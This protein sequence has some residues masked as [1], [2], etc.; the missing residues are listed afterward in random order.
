MKPLHQRSEFALFLSTSHPDLDTQE[1]NDEARSGTR[2]RRRLDGDPASS[3]R[4]R[5]TSEWRRSA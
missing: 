4:R 5:R 2:S 3:R 1:E